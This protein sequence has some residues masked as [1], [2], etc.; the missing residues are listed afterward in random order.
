MCTAFV[1]L[2]RKEYDFINPPNHENSLS[3]LLHLHSTSFKNTI[4]LSSSVGLTPGEAE[5]APHYHPV[6]YPLF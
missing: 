6:L 2:N 4:D 5:G 1:N 3:V